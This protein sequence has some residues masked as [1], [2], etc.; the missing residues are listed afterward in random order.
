LRSLLHAPNLVGQ[1][2][3][4]PMKDAHNKAAEH[5]ESA[6]K[7]HRS[8]ADSHGKNDHAEAKEHSTQARQQSQSAD[9]HSR[10]AHE[11]A[12]NRG[13][14]VEREAD[15]MPA[16]PTEDAAINAEHAGFWH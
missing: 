13:N 2:E 7:S 3:E 15:A 12:T 5:H 9:E 16:S 4:N 11:K 10:A 1:Q 6:A 8:A 14:H